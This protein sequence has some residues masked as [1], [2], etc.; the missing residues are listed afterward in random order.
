MKVD[1]PK[2]FADVLY[3]RPLMPKRETIAREGR[4]ADTAAVHGARQRARHRCHRGRMRSNFKP[5]YKGAVMVLW[6]SSG[7]WNK[8]F[9]EV[10]ILENLALVVV[11]M[12][13]FIDLKQ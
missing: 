10:N 4:G 8:I 7:K 5:L 12:V 1:N 6:F 13:H 9:A 2:V 11:D 3:G